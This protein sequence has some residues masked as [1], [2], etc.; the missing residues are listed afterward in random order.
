MSNGKLWFR[1]VKMKDSLFSLGILSLT[2]EI[3][4]FMG[5][6]GNGKW[7]PCRV[8]WT[9]ICTKEKK[10]EVLFDL[11]KT[12][13]SGYLIQKAP[14]KESPLGSLYSQK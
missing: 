11:L 5:S 2:Y 4:T 9:I 6:D 10:A 7:E 1:K 3:E 14:L 12:F 8:V 13:P